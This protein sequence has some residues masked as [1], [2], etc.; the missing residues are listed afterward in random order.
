MTTCRLYDRVDAQLPGDLGKG[1]TRPLVVHRGGARDHAQAS[2]LSQIRDQRFG[3]AIGEI[4]LRRLAGEIP[5]RE[6]R[7]GVNSR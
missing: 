5:Q 4:F 3:H 6:H 1:L 7:N 2:N